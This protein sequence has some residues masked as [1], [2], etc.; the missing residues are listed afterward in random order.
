M[1]LDLGGRRVHAQELGGQG[2]FLAGRVFE[3]QG[4]RGFVQLD[5]GGDHGQMS[6]LCRTLWER[7]CGEGACPRSTAKQS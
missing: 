6:V 1:A 5:V 7:A 2:V 4:F 3:R